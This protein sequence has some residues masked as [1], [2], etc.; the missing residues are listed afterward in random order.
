MVACGCARERARAELAT[1]VYKDDPDGKFFVQRVVALGCYSKSGGRQAHD[2]T[3]EKEFDDG[4]SARMVLSEFVCALV[5]PPLLEPSHVSTDRSIARACRLQVEPLVH[6]P[7]VHRCGCLRG[8]SF[9]VAPL[10]LASRPRFQPPLTDSQR[11]A[12]HFRAS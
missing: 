5:P 2:P 8:Q 1:A 12:T 4:G 7:S 10:L 6:T 3:K 11:N 9:A